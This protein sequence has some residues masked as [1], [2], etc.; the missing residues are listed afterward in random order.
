MKNKPKTPAHIQ[1]AIVELMNRTGPLQ[2]G[3]HRSEQ[4]PVNFGLFTPEDKQHKLF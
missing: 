1:R 4:A 3:K 2:T